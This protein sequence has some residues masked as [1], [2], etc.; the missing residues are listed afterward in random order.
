MDS[1]HQPI[2]DLVF[3]RQNTP[4]EQNPAVIYLATLTSDHSKRNMRRHLDSIASMISDHQLDSRTLQWGA[5][6][7]THTQAIRARLIAGYAPAT[8]NVMLSALRG[9]L[10]E[11]WQLGQMKAEDYQL[12]VDIENVKV[13]SLPTG[14]DLNAS[15]ISALSDACL[16]DSSPAGVRD[17]A[18]IGV[19]YTCGLRR[20]EIA[21]L[22]VGDY[23]RETGQLRIMNSKSD[24]DRTVYVTNGA[25]SALHDWLDVRGNEWGALFTPINRGGKLSLHEMTDQAIYNMIEKR[26]KQARLDKFTPHDLRRTFVGDMLDQGVDIVT[27]QKIAGHSS[28]DTTARYD[29]RPEEVKKEAAEKLHFPYRNRAGG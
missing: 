4:V 27:V 6:R 17:A 1:D 10:K 9:V 19:L 5:L 11:A 23:K 28:P 22:G 13:E 7:H 3:A 25:Q 8:V 29:R 26:M 20:A 2:S 24:R 21:H 18:M 15:E 12:A 16:S 14:R